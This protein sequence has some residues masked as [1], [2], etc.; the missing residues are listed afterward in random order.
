[1]ST[2]GTG[3]AR[4]RELAENLAAVRDRI[5]RA[6]RAVDREPGGVTL[7]VVT[8]Y[9]P[10][11]DVVALAS[12]GVT[13]VGENRYQE[14]AEKFAEVRAQLVHDAPRL[15]FIGQVQSNK[16]TAIA[17][18]ADVVHTVDRPKLIAPLARG[19][20][21][22]SRLGVLVQCDLAT[23]PGQADAAHRPGDR[24]GARPESVTDLADR[25]AG[26][27]DL[28]LRGVMAVAPLGAPPEPAFDR[29]ADLSARVRADHPGADWISAGMSGDLEA[30]I[31]AGA[32]HLRV[33][34]AILGTRPPLR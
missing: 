8:K 11:A 1:M 17:A 14:A 3:A 34:S 13:D 10:A 12:L 28:D 20:R 15:H 26:E 32:T 24:G 27:A 29:L 18:L 33:G 30:A 25:L 5:D 23:G 4:S 6:C 9:F 19:V 16:A 7:I 21:P 22:G 2:T 31:R